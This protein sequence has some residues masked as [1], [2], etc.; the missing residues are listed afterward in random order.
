MRAAGLCVAVLVVAS[1]LPAC[2]Q[3]ISGVRFPT[4]RVSYHSGAKRGE[5]TTEAIH[6]NGGLRP[7]ELAAKPADFA[8]DLPSR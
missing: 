2:R 1:I 3:E 5:V 4:H 8:P 7:G 6:V